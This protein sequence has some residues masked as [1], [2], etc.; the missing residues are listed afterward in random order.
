MLFLEAKERPPSVQNV[1]IFIL[2]HEVFNRIYLLNVAAVEVRTIHIEFSIAG[3][4]K[5][6]W[7]L[8]QRY[9][10]AAST[11]DYHGNFPCLSAVEAALPYIYGNFSGIC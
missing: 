10:S 6:P 3:I 11:R 4:K 7:M 2:Q 8:P 5:N 1:L 9:G